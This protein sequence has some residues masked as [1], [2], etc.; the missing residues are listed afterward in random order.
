MQ[1]LFF[2]LNLHKFREAVLVIRG[3]IK[4]LFRNHRMP[5]LN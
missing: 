1:M 3:S 2:A 4:M 5:V